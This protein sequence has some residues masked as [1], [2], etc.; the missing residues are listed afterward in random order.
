MKA[1]FAEAITEASANRRRTSNHAEVP[2]A[3]ASAKT[4]Y[5]LNNVI[6]ILKFA[7]KP[8]APVRTRVDAADAHCMTMQTCK[9]L[10]H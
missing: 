2:S 10:S 6:C 5:C 9:N 1:N 8:F 7:L 3:E 4:T